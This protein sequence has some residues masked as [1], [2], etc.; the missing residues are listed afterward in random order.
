MAQASRGALDALFVRQDGG[1]EAGPAPPA[2]L[3]DLFK[4]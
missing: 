3:D 2:S 4:K 1:G